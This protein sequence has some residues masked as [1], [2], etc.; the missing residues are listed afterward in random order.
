VAD[1]AAGPA[2]PRPWGVAALLLAV[3]DTLAARFSACAVHGQ[4]SGF[5]RAASG[6]CYFTLKDSDGAAAALRCAMFRR[7]AT[8]VD[9]VPREG[10]QVEL[11]G[12][13]ALFEPR[14][15]MQFI[16]ESMRALGAGSL[17]EQF[18]RL[19]ARLEADGLF[20]AARK[21]PLPRFPRI[22]GV[23][24]STAGAALHDVLTTLARRAPHV[25][26]VLYPSPVQGAEAPAALVAALTAAAARR[27]VDVLIVARGGGSIEDLWAFNDER[28]V[29][30]VAGMPMP[31][32]AGVG[33]ETDV[34]LVDFAADLRAPTP[35]AAAEQAAPVTDELLAALAALARR[36]RTRV[37]HRLEQHDQRL[38]RLSLRLARPGQR[39]AHAQRALQA[40]D[41]RLVRA[42]SARL[43]Q[44]AGAA[45]RAQDR[46]Q[47]AAARRLQRE[48][49]RLQTL[50]A[51][52]SA[53]DPSRVLARGY[54][55]VLDETERPLL[56]A[57]AARPGQA[58]RLHWHDGTRSARVDAG[59]VPE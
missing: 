31:V 36:L 58:L 46:L 17:H 26:V 35:T 40:L 5:T 20:D 59:P 23:V 48:A 52:L 11:R 25:R 18:L 19:K 9:F 21:R 27:E 43:A 29:R 15:E 47:A 10:Q 45:S 49:S 30:A 13:I 12:R 41:H 39:L 38:D 3:G 44:R 16:V 22:V 55:F 57:H 1:A 34:T 4:L 24:T 28:V 53:L 6:H 54:V 42:L 32:I 50:A 14:G 51:R 8:L 33:H 2:V 56:S 37:A 7:A